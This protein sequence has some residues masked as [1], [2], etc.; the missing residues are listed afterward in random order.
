MITLLPTLPGLLTAAPAGDTPA[1]QHEAAH[2][3]LRDSLRCYARTQGIPLSRMPEIARTKQGKPYFPSLPDVH[4]SLSH[5][6]GLAACLLAAQPCGVD[7]EA[8]RPL[9]P[10]VIRRSY[11]PEEQAA[12]RTAEDP[13]LLFTQLWTLKEA[14]VK[15]T[16]TGIAYPLHTLVFSL[17][18][19]GVRSSA[20]GTFYHTLYGTFA[21]SACL[22]PRTR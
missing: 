18:E 19:D 9:R 14:Y 17:T 1:Q 22:L 13:E 6:R 8:R 16:G 7:A 15:A 4:F 5:C 20:G 3:L 12:L 21:V 11:A 10:Q 2:A